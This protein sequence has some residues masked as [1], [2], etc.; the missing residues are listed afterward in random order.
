MPASLGEG[1]AR[2]AFEPTDLAAPYL[3]IDYGQKGLR[4]DRVPLS[5]TQ[6][7]DEI[8]K[9]VPLVPRPLVFLRFSRND[10]DG[11]YQLA[12]AIRATG[13]C[14]EVSCLFQIV[15]Q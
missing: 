1:W 11:A 3:M 15:E 4:F 14:S 8:R 5:E 2:V 6:T 9:A 13:A 10:K 7:L 12:R